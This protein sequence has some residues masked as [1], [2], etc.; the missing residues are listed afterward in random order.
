MTN[1]KEHFINSLKSCGMSEASAEMIFNSI[2][3]GEK[4]NLSHPPENII[5]AINT[6]DPKSPDLPY[7][8]AAYGEGFCITWQMGPVKI[9]GVNGAQVATVLG[10]VLQRLEFLQSCFPCIENATSIEHLKKAIQS[11]LDR[12]N[13]RVT[14]GTEGTNNGFQEDLDTMNEHSFV[15]ATNQYSNVDLVL[16]TP[17]IPQCH[18]V[19]VKTEEVPE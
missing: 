7:G 4:L 13:R 10:A 9:N 14:Q 1:A 19:D 15:W 17:L 18:R 5:T 3:D 2:P 6:T 16:T 11:Q 12:T 8:G